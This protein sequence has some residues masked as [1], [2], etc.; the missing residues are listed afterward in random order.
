MSF[1]NKNKSKN[2]N[3]WEEKMML[4][5]YINFNRV[6]D[7]YSMINGGYSDYEVVSI[8]GKEE[9]KS[10]IS[11]KGSFSISHILLNIGADAGAKSEKG[12][13]VE[14]SS[15]AKKVQTLPS[16]LK[17]VYD[18]LYHN[19]YINKLDN[20]NIGDF[21]EL[22]VRFKIN[23]MRLYFK[24]IE[25]FLTF[26]CEGAN[27][28]KSKENEKSRKESIK[29]FKDIIESTKIVQSMFTGDELLDNRL[30]EYAV[31][32]RFDTDNLY[33]GNVYSIA[34]TPLKCLAQIKNIYHNGTNLLKDNLTSKIKVEDF[35][36]PLMTLFNNSQVNDT[37]NIDCD[38][39]CDIKN[40]KVYE[41]E[42]ISL[43]R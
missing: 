25:N 33:T 30:D 32:G 10:E 11:G 17:S 40:K 5:Y 4:P 38:I 12:H 9:K 16:M 27:L 29:N 19:N 24:E 21:I 2:E 18:F 14:K 41:L 15:E 43:F 20:D 13:I 22:D 39:V 35:I 36:N 26:C 7:L 37:F 6:L 23:S 34:D 42:I 8:S 28:D 31:F 3:S 1:L